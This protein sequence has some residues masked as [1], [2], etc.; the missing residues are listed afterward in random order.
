M[1]G[2]VFCFFLKETLALLW[3]RR[4]SLSWLKPV[5]NEE[6]LDDWLRLVGDFPDEFTY[7]L[8]LCMPSYLHHWESRLQQRPAGMQETFWK[9]EIF[10]WDLLCG[11]FCMIQLSVCMW[12]KI[13]PLWTLLLSLGKYYGS[14][15]AHQQITKLLPRSERIGISCVSWITW[16]QISLWTWKTFMFYFSNLDA[17]I[18][19][20]RLPRW[21][22]V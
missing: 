20:H 4:A 1:D 13:L 8:L 18:H 9:R 22:T 6:V 19:P 10:A 5:G 11:V 3:V 12:G 16:A 17:T 2:C 14:V 7:R 15:W 21:L